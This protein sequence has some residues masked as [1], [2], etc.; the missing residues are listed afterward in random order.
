MINTP[1][2]VDSKPEISDKSGNKIIDFIEKDVVSQNEFEKPNAINFYLLTEEDSMRIDVV[3]KKMYGNTDYI[4]NV[5]KFNEISNPY[6][7]EEGEVLYIYDLPST[8]QN[9]RST[10]QGSSERNDIRNQYLTPEKKSTVDPE[11]KNYEKR[12][13]ARNINAKGNQPPLPPNYAGFG[14]T[15]IT[16][17]NGKIVFGEN[18]TKN[19]NE[20]NKPL[21]KSEFIAK[22]VKNRLNQ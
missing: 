2:T 13:V 1:R 10:K 20:N 16:I 15:E 17:K 7:V 11:L 4:E 8:L 12:E 3:T 18:V 5:L 19:G 9:L 21:A 14:E 6:T 22:I